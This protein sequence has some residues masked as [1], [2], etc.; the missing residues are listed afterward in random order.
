MAAILG[1]L[2]ILVI[3]LLM[4]G[5]RWS[6]AWAGVAGVVASLLIAIVGFD[7]PHAT[8]PDVGLAEALAGT[9]AEAGF[10]ALTILWIIGPAIGIHHLQ[11]RTGA[12]E[13]LRTAL[14]GIAPDARILALLVAWFFVLFMEGAAGFG[15]SVAL[16]APFLV[17][18]GF[19]PVPAVVITLVGH[20][21]GVSFG[22]IGTPI[23]PQVAV[24][25]LS[26]LE[27]ARSTGIYHSILGWFPL[28][29]MLVLV[30]RSGLESGGGRAIWGWF[31]AAF[32]C[33]CVPYTLLWMFVGPELPTL[34][35]A[36]FGG[37]VFIAL[38]KMLGRR[39]PQRVTKGTG[40]STGQ[41]VRAAAPYLVLVAVVLLTRLVPPL[42]DGLRRIGLAWQLTGG[43]SGTMQ[44]LYHPGTMLLLGFIAG[45]LLQRAPAREVAGAVIDATRR[46]IP[47]AV[48]LTSML[49][50]SRIMVHA[51]MTQAL[52]VAA[53]GGAG[54]AW[55]L[56]APFV[57]GLG[58][59]VTGS[60]TASNILFTAFQRDTALAV[61]LPVAGVVGLQGFGAAVGNMICPHNVVAAGATVGLQGQEG[62]ILRST[63]WVTAAYTIMGGLLGLYVVRG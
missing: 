59:F 11:L 20:V 22:A 56:L 40:T 2:P 6:A 9:A 28:L 58:T 46:L 32:L 25:S 38:L 37:A 4:L 45:A 48:A 23:V 3:L 54:V 53:A 47:V 41:V 24:T 5:L 14:R 21:V 1:A 29:V 55:P 34:A 62:E 10:T 57:G 43:F 12:A 17:A 50:L 35:G 31:A 49:V 15:A 33:F 7:F 36:L 39:K 30:Q 16:A 63:L 26:G 18:A 42:Q 52:A 27:I 44:P 51:G 8:L 60:A 13:T 61:G 19:R